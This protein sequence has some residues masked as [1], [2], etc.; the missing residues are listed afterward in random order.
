MDEGS[1]ERKRDLAGGRMV[2]SIEST[3]VDTERFEDRQSNE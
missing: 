3:K 1:E 2:E